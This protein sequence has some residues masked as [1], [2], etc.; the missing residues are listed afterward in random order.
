MSSTSGQHLAL[1]SS[2][3]RCLLI[4]LVR[5]Y[6]GSSGCIWKFPRRDLPQLAIGWRRA[7]CTRPRAAA[8]SS[9][10]PGRFLAGSRVDLGWSWG[11]FGKSSKVNPCVYFTLRVC[12][13]AR[14]VC[15]IGVSA[16]DW[17]YEL[18]HSQFRLTCLQP[19]PSL[20]ASIFSS[21]RALTKCVWRDCM[22]ARALTRC[23]YIL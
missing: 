4:Q 1:P 16:G 2:W 5:L 10:L 14:A 18:H 23:I 20:I 9:W 6:F 12:E 22:N 11:G 15:R 7:T 8:R 21:H 19:L 17:G 13:C 3:L